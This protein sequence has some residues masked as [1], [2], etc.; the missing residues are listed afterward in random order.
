MATTPTTDRML[1]LSPD[2]QGGPIKSTPLQ[3]YHKIVLK[4]HQ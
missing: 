2:V 1:L 3:Y 4:T